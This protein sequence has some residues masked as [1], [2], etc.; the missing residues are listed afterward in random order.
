MGWL[1]EEGDRSKFFD[2]NLFWA[3]TL[4]IQNKDEP[5]STIF[6][7]SGLPSKFFILNLY[8]FGLAH[9]LSKRKTSPDSND[10]CG[11]K[12]NFSG[13]KQL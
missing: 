11:C 2:L 1:S 9:Y 7:L 10:S 12:P 4:F 8:N 6:V 13:Y 5:D 3:G